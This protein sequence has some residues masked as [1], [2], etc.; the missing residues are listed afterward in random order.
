MERNEQSW[1]HWVKYIRH[2]N[3]PPWIFSLVRCIFENVKVFF[4]KIRL[5]KLNS[6]LG[7]C[8]I[9]YLVLFWNIWKTNTMV[10]WMIGKE[11]ASW[12][13]STPNQQKER[14]FP[15]FFT[16]KGNVFVCWINRWFEPYTTFVFFVFLFLGS[17]FVFFSYAMAATQWEKWNCI[18]LFQRYYAYSSAVSPSSGW[19]AISTARQR[20]YWQVLNYIF[21]NTIIWINSISTKHSM[22]FNN[23]MSIYVY[24]YLCMFSMIHA[25]SVYHCGL[26]T[27]FL[28][29]CNTQQTLDQQ[30]I[31]SSE[32]RLTKLQVLMK[33]L[34]LLIRTS[35]QNG[36]EMVL[37]KRS[38][39]AEKIV[40]KMH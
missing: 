29:C 6:L 35:F 16:W 32:R 19:R 5:S 31:H 34:S 33:Y 24:T 18:L 17:V 23:S 4:A 11:R 2:V 28:T 20:L 1:E 36:N 7:K 30:K 22:D 13:N 37:K 12:K 3:L 8:I 38:G 10:E 14:V 9:C 27:V 21:A 26:V 15:P 40:T 25:W 39:S